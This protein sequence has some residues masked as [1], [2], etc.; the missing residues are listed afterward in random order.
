LA[1]RK[2]HLQQ[3]RDKL[4]AAKRK[5]REEEL[6]RYQSESPEMKGQRE[7]NA[8][9][10]DNDCFSIFRRYLAC[11]H[12]QNKSGILEGRLLSSQSEQSEK[13]SESLD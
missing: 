1:Q 11:L 10:F 6:S 12:H 9:I 5:Q 8:I 7:G 4:L 13:F 2:Q 3:Q